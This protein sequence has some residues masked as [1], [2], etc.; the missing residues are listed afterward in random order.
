MTILLRLEPVKRCDHTLVR[1]H[2]RSLGGIKHVRALKR[3]VWG[4]THMVSLEV[5]SARVGRLNLGVVAVNVGLQGAGYLGTLV[6]GQ[7]LT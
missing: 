1:G 3:P 2:A 4:D 7:G 5:R 6:S